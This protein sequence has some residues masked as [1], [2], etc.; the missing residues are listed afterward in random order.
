MGKTRLKEWLKRRTARRVSEFAES[1]GRRKRVV[2]FWKNDVEK[3]QKDSAMGK[4]YRKKGKKKRKKTWLAGKGKPCGLMDYVFV[5]AREKGRRKR[6]SEIFG[7]SRLTV[8]ES[9]VYLCV[10]RA[11]ETTKR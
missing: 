10:L 5:C 7:K 3:R 11:N 1:Q 4:K 9:A 6:N 8:W 2:S